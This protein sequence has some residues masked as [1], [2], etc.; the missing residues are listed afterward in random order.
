MARTA[1]YGKP[2]GSYN[3]AEK[4]RAL[5]ASA[6]RLFEEKGYHATSVED[7]VTEAG[8]TKGA[9]YHLFSGKEEI[10]QKLQEEY[11]DDRLENF[12]RIL[13]NHSSPV[14]RLR[15]LILE[16]VTA[17]TQFRSH[18]IIF[19]QERRF[20]TEDRFAAIKTKRDRL[21]ALYESIIQQGI[22]DGVFD[23]RLQPRI[24]SFGIL[25]MLTSAYSWFRPEGPLTAAEVADQFA[26]IVLNGLLADG[27]DGG[28]GQTVMDDPD[29]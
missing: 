1:A 9:L 14:D 12:E 26:E 16:S 22:D 25:G 19:A 21:D 3:P 5:L 2:R 23:S 17:I 11:I 24:V 15:Q 28:G 20:L 29:G 13:R 8:M 10:L 7:I 4:R 18:V 27:A 6:L